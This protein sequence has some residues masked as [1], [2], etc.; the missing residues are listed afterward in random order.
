MA[1]ALDA[2]DITL[3]GDFV[4]LEYLVFSPEKSKLHVIYMSASCAE[5][6]NYSRV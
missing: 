6:Y 3:S 5:C 2:V 4:L 1:V